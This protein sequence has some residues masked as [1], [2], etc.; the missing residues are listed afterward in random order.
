MSVIRVTDR[1]TETGRLTQE[2]WDVEAREPRAGPATAGAQGDTWF[3]LAI[4]LA[5]ALGAV[6]RFTYLFRGAPTLVLGDGFSYSLEALRIA[7]GLGYTS[8]MGDVGAEFAHHPPGWVTVLAGVAELGGRSMRAQQITGLVIGLGVI[9]VTGIVGR[10]YVGLR[11]GA[12][13]AFLAAIYPG[14]WVLDVQI[15]S[16][17]LGLLVAGLLALL[18][19]DLWQRPTLGR[20]I[21]AGGIVGALALVRSE[22]LGLFVIA[23]AP[24]LLFNHRIA[25]HRRVAWTAAATVTAAVLIAP[26]TIYNLGRFEEPVI[27]ST[28]VGSTLLAGNCPPGT[29]G[30]ERMG[31]YDSCFRELTPRVRDMDRSQTDLEARDVAF[32][33]M[34]D[35]VD[36]LPATVLAR[37]GR[38]LGVFRPAQTVGFVALWFGSATWP[39]WAWVASFWLLAPLAAYGSVVLRRARTFQWPLVAPLI[40]T[41]LVVTVAYGEPRYHTPAD[42]GLVVLAAVGLERLLHRPLRR[43]GRTP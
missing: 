18:L 13:A 33:N 12:I 39:V 25:L 5:V 35:N 4:A 15:L 26:W 20:A 8:A 24:I 28:N 31:Y 3:W 21:L 34:R 23:I 30:G 16:E 36:R 14:F 42:L 9:V 2:M 19:A 37:Y 22:Q 6:V 17:P 38:T 41:V 40:I 29:Y 32:D 27:L 1:T 11:V 43:W 10:R 7:D